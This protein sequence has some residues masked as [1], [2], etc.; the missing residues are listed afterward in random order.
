MLIRRASPS[1][2][3]AIAEIFK[4]AFGP[5]QSGYTPAAY[6]NTV[7]GKEVIQQRMQEGFSWV[8]VENDFTLGT[9]SATPTW[10]GLYVTGMAVSPKAQG[11]KA[12]FKLMCS[13]EELAT[14][15]S[16]KRLYLYTTPF[17]DRAIN[18]YEK[19]GFRRYGKPDEQWMGTTLIQFEKFL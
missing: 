1:D 12:G 2:S 8:A 10:D 17:L 19:F 13:L 5:F 4:E 6:A 14:Q 7:V 16:D 15:R 9:V 3:H 18:L 11:K